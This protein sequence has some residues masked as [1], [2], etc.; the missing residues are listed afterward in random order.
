MRRRGRRLPAV[1]SGLLLA[2]LLVLAGIGIG[3]GAVGAAVIDVGGLAGTQKAAP[4]T[5]AP[6]PA[7]GGRE[8]EAPKP[9]APEPGAPKPEA[10][11]PGTPKPAPPKPGPP[12]PGPPKPGP[13]K[14][15]PP[16]SAPAGPASAKPAARTSTLGV[17]A[18]DAP[19]GAGALLV[20]VH[21][22]GPGH[23]AGLVHGDTLLAFGGTRVGSAAALA[24][25]V[26]EAPP[27]TRMT[28]TVRHKN[29]TRQ[30]LAVK[31]GI[32]T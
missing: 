17:E 3:V 5:G 20:G 24:S 19:G 16:D 4:T 28:L 22:P 12:K 26:A 6:R 9:G 30:T 10:P 15:A 8:S 32:V 7:A 21:I 2:V 27:G 23:T 11:E 13:P 29:G 14:S 18:V 1:L 31:P 25:A